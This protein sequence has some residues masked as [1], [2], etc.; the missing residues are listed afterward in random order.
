MIM[1]RK[2]AEHAIPINPAEIK[3][4]CLPIFLTQG[5]ILELSQNL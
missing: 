4:F 2:T 1:K 3:Q 5:V